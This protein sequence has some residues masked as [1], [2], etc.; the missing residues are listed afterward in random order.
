MKRGM[1][2]LAVLIGLLLASAS[3]AKTM[4]SQSAQEKPGHPTCGQMIS[5]MAPIPAKLSEG[6][7][8]VAEMLDAHAALMGKDK[9]SVAEARGMRAVAKT[10]RHIAA[11]LADASEEM[12]KA[13]TWPAAPHDAAMMGAD[14][15]LAAA[16]QKVIEVHKAIIAMFQKMVADMEAGAKAAK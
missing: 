13:V 7:N 8:S 5:G 15:K 9:D 11:A 6:A 1:F 12:K 14:P 4:A 10:H 2:Y 16:T 3:I